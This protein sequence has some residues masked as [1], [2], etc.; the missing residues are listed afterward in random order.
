MCH[1]PFQLWLLH[2]CVSSCKLLVLYHVCLLPHSHVHHYGARTMT[3]L[4]CEPQINSFF[5]KCLGHGILSHQLKNIQNNPF[6]ITWNSL[7]STFFGLLL[8]KID[9][10]SWPCFPLTPPLSSSLQPPYSPRSTPP[11]FPLQKRAGLQET[12]C[13]S[14]LFATDFLRLFIDSWLNL[15]DCM[16][17]QVSLSVAFGIFIFWHMVFKKNISCCSF[18]WHILQYLLFYLSFYKFISL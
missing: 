9:S 13:Y 1:V 5:C 16:C 4:T 12:L 3:I 8:L 18:H 17:P 10:S 15:L 14:L 2:G 7:Y 11:S 6:L